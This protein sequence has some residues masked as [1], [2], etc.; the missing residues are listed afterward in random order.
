MMFSLSVE[1]CLE[2]KDRI[3]AIIILNHTN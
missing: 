2:N 1:M 3:S